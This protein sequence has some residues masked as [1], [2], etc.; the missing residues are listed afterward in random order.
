[1]DGRLGLGTTGPIQARTEPLGQLGKAHEISRLRSHGVCFAVSALLALATT[2]CGK[3]EA[4]LARLVPAGWAAA[5]RASVRSALPVSKGKNLILIT[6]DTCRADR[7]A[8]YGNPAIRTPNIDAI[9]ANGV[10]FAHAVCQAPTT[11]P[12]HCSIFTGL[13]PTGHGVRD[14]GRFRLDDSALTLAEVLHE[15]GYRT[16]AFIGAFPVAARFGLAQGFDTYSEEL[17]RVSF[18]G[19]NAI[20]E[21]PAGQVTDK[22]LA[23]LA[24]T[25]DEPFFAW[26]HYFDPHWP[27]EPP[28]AYAAAYSSALY[29][30]EIAFVDAQIGRLIAALEEK[31]IADETLVAVMADHGEGLGEHNEYSHSILLYDGTIRIPLSIGVAGRA[32]LAEPGGS[33]EPG[34]GFIA[35]SQARSVDVMPTVLDLLAL[36]IPDALDGVSLRGNETTPPPASA[37]LSYLETYTP[38]YGFQ[39]SPLRGLRTDAWK[40]VEAP[41]PKLFDLAADPG[42]RSNVLERDDSQARAWERALRDVGVE[43]TA[44]VEREMDAETVEKLRALGYVGAGSSLAGSRPIGASAKLPDPNELIDLYFRFIAPATELFGRGDY[45]RTIL[46][47]DSAVATDSTNL[48]AILIRSHALGRVGR[49]DEARASYERVFELDPESIS[50]HFSLGALFFRTG[51]F[52]AAEQEYRAVLSIDPGLNEARH[53][54]ALTL[55]NLGR[56]AEAET[57]FRE[58]IAADST[59]AIAYRSLGNLYHTDGRMREA[60][61]AYLAALAIDPSARDVESTVLGL[62]NQDSLGV[63]ALRDVEAAWREDPE[64]ERRVIPFAEVLAARGERARALEILSAAIARAPSAALYRIR[65]WIHKSEGRPKMALEDLEAAVAVVPEDVNAHTNLGSYYR[66]LGRLADAKREYEAALTLDNR[67][68]PALVG[69]GIVFAEW[70]QLGRA[71]E[72]WQR[73]LAENSESAAKKNL[74]MARQMLEERSQ[75]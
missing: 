41:R 33:I 26:V 59:F 47:C 66:S 60:L 44:S 39:W 46:Y 53:D 48:Q 28:G 10:Q 16:G 58:T 75:R 17:P 40:F 37:G 6:I 21:R 1:V 65:A 25:D 74:E 38:W 32:G 2:G 36:P 45:G 64:S 56:T 8:C 14:N 68:E 29:D 15:H 43:R 62:A 30:G 27:Y 11:L 52:A 5:E 69:L 50:A 63:A 3:Q 55:R 12:S 51:E 18:R 31:G 72:L 73:A 70:Q 34:A 13:Y 9:A 19:K 22:T 42:E 61:A 67:N 57:M 4:P 24:A 20:A 54:L 23:W 71:M 35:A 49:D 7:L